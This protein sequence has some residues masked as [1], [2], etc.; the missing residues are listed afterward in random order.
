MVVGRLKLI[1]GLLNVSC[2]KRCTLHWSNKHYNPRSVDTKAKNYREA[3]VGRASVAP[4]P[5]I[6][7]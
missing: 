4:N 7:K 6:G 2:A 1:V 3:E 5:R